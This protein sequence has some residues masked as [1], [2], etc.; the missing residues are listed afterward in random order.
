MTA[1][2]AEALQLEPVATEK[3][4]S[5]WGLAWRRLRRH[6]LAMIGLYILGAIVIASLLAQW[7][8]PY[9]YEEINLNQ[10][11]TPL[12]SAGEPGRPIHYLGT[13]KLGRDIF[14]RL[15]YA[16]RISLGVALIVELLA[17][18]L[19]AIVGA[20]AG[21]FGRAVDTVLMRFADV[22]LTLPTLPL[23]LVLSSSLR[24]FVGLQKFLGSSL[25]VAI[26][27]FV[28][29]IFGWM[30]VA[31]L[32]RGSVLSLREQN[33]I[34]AT[35]ALGG[36]QKRIIFNHLIPNSLAPIIVAAT[37]GFGGVIISESA[38][39]FLGFGIMPPVPT[40]GNMLNEA[41]NSPL[42]YLFVQ[43]LSPGFCIFITVLCVNFLG[44][45][46]RDALDP[47]LKL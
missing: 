35:R 15:L 16:G 29:V 18:T 31:R 20:V 37:L 45:G 2:T 22:M 27:V 47:R 12:M 36:G 44:D 14:S 19:G 28:L 25:S 4:I 3:P 21:A 46:L 30:G 43:A 33:F 13:D 17:I 9:D 7:I 23:L 40:W 41:R 6:R 11:F 24:Q 42:E 38:L 39:S 8:A 1:T 10:S 34:E 26:I 5:Q 32:V